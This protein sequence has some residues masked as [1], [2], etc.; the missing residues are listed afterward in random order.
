MTIDAW[1]EGKKWQNEQD[2]KWQSKILDYL[3]QNGPATVEELVKTVGV[4]SRTAYRFRR[5]LLEW[6]LLVPVEGSRFAIHGYEEGNPEYG[7]QIIVPKKNLAFYLEHGW[8]YLNDTDKSSVLAQY[9]RQEDEHG[10]QTIQFPDWFSTG[11]NVMESLEN[12]FKNMRSENGITPEKLEQF[13]QW[14]VDSLCDTTKPL[15]VTAQLCSGSS[16][17]VWEAVSKGIMKGLGDEEEIVLFLLYE[18]R[19]ALCLETYRYLQRA[20]LEM[21]LVDWYDLVLLFRDRWNG[22]TR[23]ADYGGSLELKVADHVFNGFILRE[24]IISEKDGSKYIEL[25]YDAIK[26]HSFSRNTTVT[27]FTKEYQARIKAYDTTLLNKAKHHNEI[28]TLYRHVPLYKVK[29]R[30]R[31]RQLPEGDNSELRDVG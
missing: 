9:S 29:Q 8:K 30:R 18:V 13:K 10:T 15:V 16:G 7:K 14:L 24:D 28:F 11:R 22:I 21:N 23:R 2:T 26:W 31:E 1:D 12:M 20:R 3:L 6:G 19:T 25:I 17:S 5:T 4:S 27:L